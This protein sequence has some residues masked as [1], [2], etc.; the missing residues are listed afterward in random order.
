MKSDINKQEHNMFWEKKAITNKDFGKLI[1]QI[2]EDVG[3]LHVSPRGLHSLYLL[4]KKSKIYESLDIPYNIVTIN[5]KIILS[6]ESG[7]KQFV[8]IVLPGDIKNRN[9][10]SIY[11]PIGLA[12]LGA[13]E[14][15]YVNVNF[16]NNTQRFLI[17]KVVF[18]PEKENLLYL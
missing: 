14:K 2:T 8:T 7:Q 5:S 17:E 12:C 10:V 3:R 9:D 4:L 18:Q 11:S 1:N 13:K 15:D 16:K 6:T